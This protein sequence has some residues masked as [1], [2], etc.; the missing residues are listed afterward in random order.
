MIT[1]SYSSGF[2]SEFHVYTVVLALAIQENRVLLLKNDSSFWRYEESPLCTNQRMNTMDCF[3]LPWSKCTLEDAYYA[4]EIAIHG[5]NHVIHA[6]RD[7]S[8]TSSI[9]SSSSVFTTEEDKRLTEIVLK[10]G[11]HR[12]WQQIA[13]EL[14]T[15][16]TPIQCYQRWLETLYP[17]VKR[18]SQHEVSM[19]NTPSLTSSF[20]F[21][22]F[23]S[24]FL[25]L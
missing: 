21:V 17:G 9:S 19:H 11:I 8:S 7:A 25:L 22:S 10:Y 15:H 24:F 3:L 14:N 2:G 16:K 5:R 20:F 23:L 6:E 12:N 13:H 1:E 4:N 18:T